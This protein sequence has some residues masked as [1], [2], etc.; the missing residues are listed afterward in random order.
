M[1]RCFRNEQR[2]RAEGHAGSGMAVWFEMAARY[3]PI[4]RLREPLSLRCHGYACWV[5]EGWLPATGM[6][7]AARV[8]SFT[9]EQFD[10]ETG[11]TFLRACYRDPRLAGHFLHPVLADN[12]LV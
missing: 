6:S 8:F 4:V 12:L 2:F 11:F 9:G 7:G 5:S 3:V 1:L 10:S